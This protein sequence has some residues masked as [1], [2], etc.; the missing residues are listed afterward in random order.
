MIHNALEDIT[1]PKGILGDQMKTLEY[2]SG[3]AE[4]YVGRRGEPT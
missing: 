3:R 2:R 4:F 1:K